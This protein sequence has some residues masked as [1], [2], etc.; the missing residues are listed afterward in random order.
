MASDTSFYSGVVLIAV[1]ILIITLIWLGIELSNAKESKDFPPTFGT[2]PDYWVQDGTVCQ[3]PLN[4]HPNNKG[5]FAAGGASIL[6]NTTNT[7]GFNSADNTI[8]MSNAGWK[9]GSK[10]EKCGKQGWAA[11]YGLVWDG[12]NNYNKC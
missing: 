8:D 1:I 7:P 11:N 4:K 9:S 10:T 2:C 12:I 3:I 5:L 6:L